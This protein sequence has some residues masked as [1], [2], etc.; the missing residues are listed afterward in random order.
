M[1]LEFIKLNHLI[2]AC[3]NPIEST[4]EDNQIKLSAILDKVDQ[5]NFTDEEKRNLFHDSNL[6]VDPIYIQKSNGLM[7]VMDGVYRVNIVREILE[8]YNITDDITMLC[9]VEHVDEFNIDK[10]K[11]IKVPILN[12]N[13]DNQNNQSA[14][15][16][17]V[18]R[19]PNTE[20][21]DKIDEE[22]QKMVFGRVNQSCTD[23]S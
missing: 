15:E 5:S 2:K 13:P 9:N 11:Q 22:Y 20:E 21:I 19:I 6:I 17:G 7:K 3:I 10:L 4:K 1:E 16:R 18:L 8:S 23:E 14:I 12:I